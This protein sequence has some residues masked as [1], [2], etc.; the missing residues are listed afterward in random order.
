MRIGVAGINGRVGS[1][2]IEAIRQRG[3]QLTGGFDRP[4]AGRQAPAPD[5]T[6]FHSLEELAA[7][8]DVVVDFTVA[9]AVTAHSNAI[10]RHRAA[11]VLGTTGLSEAAQLGVVQ[12]ARHVPV[13]Q[14]ANFS[15]GV[16]LVLDLAARLAAALPPEDYDAEIVD[17]HHRQK[18]DA[19][20]GTAL[21]IGNAVAAARG[22]TLAAVRDSGRDGVTSARAT[23]AIGF[24]SLRG[25]QVV[26]EHTVLFTASDEQIGLTHRAFD[27]RTFAAGAIRAAH[28]AHGRPPGLYSMRDVLGLR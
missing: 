6:L 7:V 18:L 4:G 13:V 11:W 5:I 22:T 20:S 21:A 14:A 28:W 26:G 8:S 2:L 23:G 17:M 9:A 24:A 10:S 12:A 25:G 27:R 16:T 3:D 15:P 19:P 1:V